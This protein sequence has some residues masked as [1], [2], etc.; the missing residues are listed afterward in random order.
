MACIKNP[1][2][3]WFMKWSG[4][5]HRKI[6]NIS[7]WGSFSWGEYAVSYSCEFCGVNLGVRIATEAHLVGIGFD[8]DKLHEVGAFGSAPEK[9]RMGKA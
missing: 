4:S 1:K 9:L 7:R 2:N 6:D 5:H 8:V 3:L